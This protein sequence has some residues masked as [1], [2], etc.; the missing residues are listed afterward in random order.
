MADISPGADSNAII[1]AINAITTSFDAITKTDLHNQALPLA[2]TNW[3][4]AD[5]APTNPPCIIRV[6]VAV[7]IAGNLSAVITNG[8]NS[9]VNILNGT[10]GPA[11]V[12]GALYIF[13]IKMHVGDTL[14]LRYSTTGGTIQVLRTQEI[15]NTVA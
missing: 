6:E 2:N 11:L 13:D 14:N 5:I 15:D 3:L 7:S 4:G 1:S 12:A 9:Q 8:G 10:A